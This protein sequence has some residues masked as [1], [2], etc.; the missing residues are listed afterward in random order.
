MKYINATAEGFSEYIKENNKKIIL[1]GAGA[2][3]KTFV[4][5]ISNKYNFTNRIICVVDNNPDKQGQFVNINGRKIPITG[6]DIFNE[7]NEDY[8]VLIT[9]GEF[10]SVMCQLDGIKGCN[11]RCCFIVAYMQLEKQYNREQN[12]VYKDYNEPKIPK[13]INYC[14][15]SG[16]PMPIELVRCVNTW[17]ELCPDYDI[18]CWNESNFDL[19]KYRYTKE[20][21][22]MKKWGYIPDIV[23]LEVLYDVGGF[24]FDTDVEM[25]RNLDELRFQ[26]AF[27]GRERG[28][29]VN[30]GGGS[31]S[32]PG[33]DI[34]KEILDFRKDEPFALANGGYNSEASGYYETTPL[35][36]HGLK[37]ADVNQK[38]DKINI[39][40]SEFF[41]PYN[42][43]NGDDIRNENTFSIHHFNA[44]WLENGE[45]LRKETREKYISVK[46][47]LEELV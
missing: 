26:D 31:G 37:V 36:E 42:Y 30:F 3:C 4:P 20:A 11:D 16:N 12:T 18:V 8:C 29:H 7:C 23:R 45:A 35:M 1:F 19:S 33:N 34:I 28:G 32:V 41:S 40:S 2:V 24:Y 6:A 17:K 27:C 25:I 5:Y 43:I 14:W 9:N 21:A 10:Y 47:R 22:V 13:I 39:Y 44:S 38:L 46:K 15:F